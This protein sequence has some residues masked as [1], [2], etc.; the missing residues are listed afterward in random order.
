MTR[1]YYDCPIKASYMAQHHGVKIQF[2]DSNGVLLDYGRRWIHLYA[3]DCPDKYYI[4]PDSLN[5]LDPQDGDE[6]IDESGNQLYCNA[7]VWETVGGC[8]VNGECRTDK[9]NGIAFMWPK[10]GE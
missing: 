3:N 8:E 1:Y 4:H 5:I 10:R 2:V 6:G 7:G 9:R